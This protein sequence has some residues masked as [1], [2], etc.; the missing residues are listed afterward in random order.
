MPHLCSPGHIPCDGS[1]RGEPTQRMHV[2]RECVQFARSLNPNIETELQTNGLFECPEDTA[3]IAR[4]FNMVWFSLD[5][6]AEINNKHRPD[7]EGRGRTRDV[8]TN[9][10]EVAKEASVG[11]RSTIV[12]ETVSDQ[13]GVVEYYYELGIKHLAFNPVIRPICRKVK[14]TMAVRRDREAE[15]SA[16]RLQPGKA[17]Q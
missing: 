10:K 9:L 17:G 2:L 16:C 12:E 14:E 6:P 13:V 7:K 4:N 3:W 1:R 5:G 11:I 8:E 15:S